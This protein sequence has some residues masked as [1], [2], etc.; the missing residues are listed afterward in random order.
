LYIRNN[1]KNNK[2]LKKYI[3]NYKSFDIINNCWINCTDN[4]LG[5]TLAFFKILNLISIFYK[6]R[7]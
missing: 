5:K 4:S 6:G 7:K 2:K 1:E 3:D